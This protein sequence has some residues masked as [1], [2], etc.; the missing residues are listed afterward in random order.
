[1]KSTIVKPLG[2]GVL[3]L[4]VIGGLAGCHA[5]PYRPAPPY[6]PAHAYNWYP[7]DY[8]YYPRVQVYFHVSTGYY[9]YPRHGQWVRARQ[10][11]PG[12]VILPHD[13]VRIRV[14]QGEPWRY[15]QRHQQQ[16]RPYVV[17]RQERVPRQLQ[18]RS[19][20]ERDH[21]RRLYREYHDRDRDRRNR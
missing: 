20:V 11:P 2:A 9:W 21:N 13:R 12:V 17:P 14:E 18:D 10:L 6:P 16:Y 1:M 3:A 7:Y 4:V 15:V 19:R 8:F 5:Q